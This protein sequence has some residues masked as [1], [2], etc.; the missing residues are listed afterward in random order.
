MMNYRDYKYNLVT[1]KKIIEFIN[2]A[3]KPLRRK[4]IKKYALSI[5]YK[6][7]TLSDMLKKSV[8]SG[9]IQRISQGLYMGTD[10]R[11]VGS[12]EVIGYSFEMIED[13]PKIVIS[14]VKAL[15]TDGKYI[16]FAK[17][18]GVEPYLHM[19]PISFAKK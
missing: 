15:D 8:V 6:D 11:K 17:L 5:G 18:K 12:L 14:M 16:K 4:D 2:S 9:K 1:E 7:R 10:N 19:Y 3:D 13:E